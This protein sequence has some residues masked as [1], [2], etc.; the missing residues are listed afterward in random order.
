MSAPL[1]FAAPEIAPIAAFFKETEDDFEVHELP[2]YLPL[3]QGEHL[4]VRFEKRGLDTERAVRAIAEALG[5]SGRDAGYAG[6]KDRHAVTTQWASFL[7]K[8]TADE[9]RAI[10]V[11]GVRV[12]EASRHANK[13]KTGHLAGNRFV[14]RLRGIAA[15]RVADLERSL[16]WLVAHGAP[17]YFGTQ[18]FGRDGDNAARA[19]R[20]IVEGGRAPEK[21]FER[22]LLVSALQS[23]IFNALLAE[24][25]ANGE[26]GRIV[27]G[28]LVR[29][30]DSGGLFVA[31]DVA[32]VQ[33]RADRLEVSATGPMMGA[34]M[35]WP[36]RV[37]REREEAALARAG[38]TREHLDRF[39]RAGEGTRR[40]Y[41]V[42]VKD[43][44]VAAEGDV[45]TVAFTLPS[46][47]YATE[48][49]REITR[50]GAVER[51][52]A[53][54]SREEAAS[55]PVGGSDDRS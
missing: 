47:A 46:G 10:E 27:D 28:D 11:P 8:R 40:N 34:E 15:D 1:P 48:I 37:A 6:M 30:E 9:A 44:S 45:V 41:R 23:E 53:R 32:E 36:E 54:P 13:I 16:S 49:L 22:K 14:L 20:W 50:G 12:L 42:L 25:V 29:K 43:P 39:R 18:R 31:D 19:R 21:P 38:L 33:A 35:R 26:L 2:A 55:E 51:R 7:S 5:S 4:Y 3:G 24:R 17:S 52:A